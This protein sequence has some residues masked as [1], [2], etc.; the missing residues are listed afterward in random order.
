MPYTIDGVPYDLEAE[1]RLQDGTLWVPLRRLGEALGGK[2]DWI[3]P[4]KVAVLY[5]GD[6]IA[7]LTIGDKTADVDG[8]QFELQDE[9]FLDNGETWVPV[10]FFERGLGYTLNADPASASVELTSPV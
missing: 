6:R 4:N 9:P 3:S 8:Q 2:A 10:R 5:L 1:P 7:T